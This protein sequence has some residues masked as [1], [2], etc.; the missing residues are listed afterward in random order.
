[1]N[2]DRGLMVSLAEWCPE[3]P[4]LADSVR[5]ELIGEEVSDPL[6][7]SLP[8]ASVGTAGRRGVGAA[9]LAW[10]PSGLIIT[11]RGRRQCMCLG[12]SSS[13]RGVRCDSCTSV[14]SPDSRERWVSERWVL[15]PDAAAVCQSAM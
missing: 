5:V 9:D 8:R 14:V 3:C 12:P 2:A 11:S 4:D 10:E 1:M 15:G 6:L 7:L 13:S